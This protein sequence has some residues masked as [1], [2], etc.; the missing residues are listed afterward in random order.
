MKGE[1]KSK[2]SEIS[3]KKI[4]EIEKKTGGLI[5]TY[6]SWTVKGTKGSFETTQKPTHK[7]DIIHHMVLEN[8]FVSKGGV[9]IGNIKKAKWYAKNKLKVFEDYPHGVAIMVDENDNII[10]YYGYSHRGG[11]AFKIGDRIFDRDYKPVKEDYS[12]KDWKNFE[13][14]Y[15]KCLNDAIKE[16]DKWWIDDIKKDGISR[17]VPFRLRGKKVIE[18]LDEAI[19]AAKNLSNYLG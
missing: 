1:I 7:K 18:K 17:C 9:Y 3:L 5:K 4:A 2:S 14:D 16:G 12:K 15:N 13:N 6:E 10:G 8:S 19:I 11:C